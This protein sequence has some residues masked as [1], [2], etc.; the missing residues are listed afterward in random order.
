MWISFYHDKCPYFPVI[1]FLLSLSEFCRS[2][3]SGENSWMLPLMQV[4][5]RKGENWDNLIRFMRSAMIAQMSKCF[6][7]MPAFVHIPSDFRNAVGRTNLIRC[8]IHVD[9]KLYTVTMTIVSFPLNGALSRIVH[10][11]HG[12]TEWMATGVLV[13]NIWWHFLRLLLSTSEKYWTIVMGMHLLLK[14]LFGGSR[15]WC[16]SLLCDVSEWE[17]SFRFSHDRHFQNELQQPSFVSVQCC[18]K[19]PSFLNVRRFFFSKQWLEILCPLP[20]VKIHWG[21]RLSKV[22]DCPSSKT[23]RNHKKVLW[24]RMLIFSLPLPSLFG[25]WYHCDTFFIVINCSVVYWIHCYVFMWSP[26]VCCSSCH[27]FR[28]HLSFRGAYWSV[29][30]GKCLFDSFTRKWAIFSVWNSH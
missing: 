19:V 25:N 5:C 20:A 4:A 18:G 13:R 12:K 1:S 8:T 15:T 10:A 2:V 23:W 30:F 9:C 22:H 28:V 17:W 7:F 26:W 27:Q 24:G 29:D 6:S 3:A 11:V 16:E 14:E 21:N